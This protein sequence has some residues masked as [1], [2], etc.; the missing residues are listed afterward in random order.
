MGPSKP[1]NIFTTL[2]TVI[3]RLVRHEKS[4]LR[5]MDEKINYYVKSLLLPSFGPGFN[6]IPAIIKRIPIKITAPVVLNALLNST[7]HSIKTTS[8]PMECSNVPILLR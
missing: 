8:T 3:S 4:D 5:N 6:S 2:I 7:K 1:E